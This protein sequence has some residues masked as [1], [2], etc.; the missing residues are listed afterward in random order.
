M[1][2]P[3]VPSAWPGRNLACAAIFGALLIAT[4]VAGLALPDAGLM[5]VAVP[6][7]LFHIVFGLLGLGAALG[8]RPHR[9]AAF[10]L[11]FGLIDLY[12][13]LAG[14]LGLFPARLFG[15]RLADHAVHVL[16]GLALVAIGARGLRRG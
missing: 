7:D 5:S 9:A 2:T 12:Q 3:T 14:V 11:G 1:S 4:G 13:A 16:F 6:Y 10:N 15:L 8:R